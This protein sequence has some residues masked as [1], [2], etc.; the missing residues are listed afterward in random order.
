MA[1]L[2][3]LWS[4]FGLWVRSISSVV[5]LLTTPWLLHAAWLLARKSKLSSAGLCDTLA[6]VGSHLDRSW[7]M[8]SFISLKPVQ[9]STTSLLSFHNQACDAFII[10]LKWLKI[11]ILLMPIV[12]VYKCIKMSKTLYIHIN[13]FKY[14]WCSPGLLMAHAFQY[15]NSS[16]FALLSRSSFFFSLK[17]IPPSNFLR[18][19]I[20]SNYRGCF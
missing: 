3:I 10:F 19:Q 12:K 20:S 5:H 15:S 1:K 18:R 17:N 14:S 13:T 11:F 7:P 6:Q 4:E 16:S 9:E 2:E 8:L